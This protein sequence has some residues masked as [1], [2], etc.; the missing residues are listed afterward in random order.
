MPTWTLDDQNG[1]IAQGYLTNAALPVNAYNF[2]SPASLNCCHDLFIMPHADPT[3]ATHGNLLSWN[4]DCDGGIWLACHAGSALEGLFNPSNK[5]QQLNFLSNKTGNATGGGP[6]EENALILWGN[7][8]DGSPPYSYAYP[9]DPIMQ[10][11]GT[12]DAATQNGSEQIYLPKTSWRAGAKIYVWDPTH[13]DVP[14]VSPGAAAVLIS[15]RGFD[16]PSRGRVM[17]EAG[18]RHNGGTTPANIAAQRAFFNFS[19]FTATEKAVVPNFSAVPD[20]MYSNVGYSFSFTLPPGYN[21]ADFTILWSSTCG[22]TF[23]PNNQAS[24]TYTPPTSAYPTTCIIYATITDACSRVFANSKIFISG[25]N[26]SVSSNL[27]EPLCYG[28]SNGSISMT[29]ANGIA[30][31]TYNWSRVS[32]TGSGSGSGTTISSLPAGTYNITV[33]ASGGCT[34]TTTVNLGQPAL[35]T[36]STQVTNVLCNGASTGAIT[37]SVNG[38]TS[39]Y[40]FNWGGGVTTQNRI[41]IPAGSYTVTVTD[42]NACTVIAFATV[43]QLPVITVTPTPTH[44]NCNGASTGSISL[45]VSGGTSPYTYAWSNGAS[46]Q[47]ISGLPVGSYTVTVTDA[48]ACTKT[49]NATLTQPAALSLSASTTNVLCNGGNNGSIDLTVSGGIT[50]YT[51]SWSNGASTQDVSGLIAGT[52]SVT[53][54]DANACTGILSRT[55]TQPTLMSLSV[56]TVNATCPNTPD[57]SINLSVSGGT[58]PYT[59]DWDNDG[60]EGVDNDTEDLSGLLPGTYAVIVTD[61]NACTK[62]TSVTIV[63]INPYPMTPAMIN[64]N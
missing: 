60:Y 10:F 42:A 40:T 27:T 24:T 64:K 8:D 18:H 5:P 3:W 63:N 38:G 61:A 17:L 26:L 22:G 16:D 21:P 19:L 50:P 25:C 14:S 54:T 56:N 49:A 6:Y 30:P 20:T 13:A 1:S 31:Y 53:V 59:Y 2:S 45:S 51:Y 29:V 58:S 52:Y 4:L 36:A 15:G 43:T 39:P 62:T 12:I 28:N 37:L 34:K 57:G 11:M 47:N 44:I 41:N 9:T 48:N 46:T 55:I 35:L 33:T 23:S 7:H 32:P